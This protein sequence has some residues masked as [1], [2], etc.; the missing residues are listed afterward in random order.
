MIIQCPVRKKL[1]ISVHLRETSTTISTHMLAIPTDYHQVTTATTSLPILQ[2][3]FT[4]D[5]PLY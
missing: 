1:A 2:A 5:K 4:L 3:D